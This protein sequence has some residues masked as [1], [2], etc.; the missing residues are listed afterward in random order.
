MILL[1]TFLLFVNFFLLITYEFYDKYYEQYHIHDQLKTVASLIRNQ[2]TIHQFSEA[3]LGISSSLIKFNLTC[4]ETYQPEVHFDSFLL[5]C[6]ELLHNKDIPKI[7]TIFNEP[8]KIQL[9]NIHLNEYMIRYYSQFLKTQNNY[10]KR[11]TLQIMPNYT[12]LITNYTI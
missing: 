2:S 5:Y 8:Y 11:I 10:I 3:E 12:S 9:N 1:L 7:N 6:H 4:P